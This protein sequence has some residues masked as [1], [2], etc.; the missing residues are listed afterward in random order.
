M[1]SLEDAAGNL[2]NLSSTVT[3]TA[4]QVALLDTAFEALKRAVDIGGVRTLE[5]NFR[6]LT[7]SATLT[8]QEVDELRKNIDTLAKSTDY[9]SKQQLTAL[10]TAFNNSRGP[11]SLYRQENEKLVQLFSTTFKN[12]AEQYAQAFIKITEQMPQYAAKAALAN[13]ATTNLYE[14]FKLGGREG[15]VAWLA[16]M[17]DISKETDTTV[18]NVNDRFSKISKVIDDF[19]TKIGTSISTS[20]AESPYLTGGALVGAGLGTV[21]GI[22]SIKRAISGGG[23]DKASSPEGL[24]RI[25]SSKVVE[26]KGDVVNVSGGA[27]NNV[28]GIGGNTVPSVISNGNPYASGLSKDINSFRSTLNNSGPSFS[29]FNLGKLGLGIGAIGLGNALQDEGYTKT[30]RLTSIGGAALAGFSSGLGVPGAAGAAT[31]AAVSQTS[32]ESSDY[33]YGVNSLKTKEKLAGGAERQRIKTRGQQI[34]FGILEGAEI[35]RGFVG[36]KTSSEFSENA[37]RANLAE[38]Q[39]SIRGLNSKTLNGQGQAQFQIDKASFALQAEENAALA[40][41]TTERKLSLEVTKQQIQFS[42]DSSKVS[43]VGASNLAKQ[44]ASE[45]EIL[46]QT[47]NLTDENGVLLKQDVASIQKRADVEKELAGVK[48]VQS[49]FIDQETEGLEKQVQL[50]IASL[51]TELELKAVT[52]SSVDDQNKIREQLVE[53][54]KALGSI[55]SDSAAAQKGVGA[56]DKAKELETGSAKAAAEGQVIAKKNAEERLRVVQ[57]VRDTEIQ[58]NEILLG[59]AGASEQLKN[60]KLRVITAKENLDLEK[61]FGGALVTTKE[62]ELRV[63]QAQEKLAEFS[64][65]FSKSQAQLEVS[66]AKRAKFGTEGIEEEIQNMRE[67]IAQE[68]LRIEKL[69]EISKIKAKQIN[70]IEKEKLALR[71]LNSQPLRDIQRQNDLIG[72]QVQLLETLKA[73]ATLIARERGKAFEGA[74]DELAI[75]KQTLATE[76]A[77]GAGPERLFELQKQIQAQ[78]LKVASQLDFTRRSFAEQFSESSIN[79]TNGS[80]LSGGGKNGGLSDFSLLG[81]SYYQGISQGGKQRG[82]TYQKQI[83][84]LFG[85]GLDER[86]PFQDFAAQLLDGMGNIEMKVHVNNVGELKTEIPSGKTN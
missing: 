73:P 23:T 52:G 76:K 83:G 4:T 64:E 11:L 30:G 18:D 70:D 2:V 12:G 14:A 60:L 79:L 35:R 26:V 71:E 67:V 39:S 1:G 27:G 80:Y 31:I 68:D 15:A 65:R 55:K 19:K 17:K 16:A 22:K 44:R 33:L 82:Q 62:N 84:N 56:T 41:S 7:R 57:N 9:Y 43:L 40:V 77:Q 34:E 10:A 21:S 51:Q 54:L 42:Q 81:G 58:L 48:K 72:G 85:G 45:L 5:T 36:D 3:K 69:D 28:G 46:K 86:S 37:T 32:Q 49:E 59:G 47:L 74:K 53:Q 75:L 66:Q 61:K 13:A 8:T 50:K 63:V 38:Y 78:Q 24:D 6:N 25:L 29:N 20:F